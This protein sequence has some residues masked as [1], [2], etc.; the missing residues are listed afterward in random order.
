M[1]TAFLGFFLLLCEL[2]LPQ[3][4]YINNDG[5]AAGPRR[6]AAILLTGAEKSDKV[7]S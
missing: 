6:E 5:H 2:F 1:K 3:G 4:V 7:D